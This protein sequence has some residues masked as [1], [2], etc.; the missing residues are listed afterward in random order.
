[1][2]GR[3]GGGRRRDAERL[4]DEGVDVNRGRRHRDAR[5]AVREPL[6]VRVVRGVERGLAHG[7]DFFDASEED[8]GWREEREA[9]MMMLVV[10]PAKEILQPPAPL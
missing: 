4:C 1:M 8:V 7:A 2:W 10:V 5:R 6:G 3:K 9:G